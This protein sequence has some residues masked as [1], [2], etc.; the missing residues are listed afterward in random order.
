MA[1]L[2]ASMREIAEEEEAPV[3]VE[4]VE[5]QVDTVEKVHETSQPENEQDPSGNDHEMTES[6]VTEDEEA[7]E[8]GET[9]PVE[10]NADDFQH[11]HDEYDPAHASDEYDPAEHVVHAEDEYDP[12]NPSHND[13]NETQTTADTGSSTATKRPAADAASPTQSKSPKRARPERLPHALPAKA[14]DQ[15]G[16]KDAAWD[17]LMDFESSGAF[18]VSQVSRAAFSSIAAL[19]EFAQCNI[20]ARFARTPMQDIRDKNG[21]IM[22]MYHQYLDENPHIKSLQPV[23][24]FLAEAGD[25]PGLFEYGYAPPMPVTGMSSIQIPYRFGQVDK[26]RAKVSTPTV[27]STSKPQTDEFGRLIPAS[28]AP[29]RPAETSTGPTDPRRAPAASAA[30]A[31]GKPVD[32]RRRRAEQPI[33]AAPTAAPA[34]SRPADPRRRVE[35]TEVYNRLPR[36]VRSL[37]DAMIHEHRLPETINDNVLSRLNHLPEPVAMRAMEK[38]TTADLSQ[39]ENIN[40]FLVGIINRVQERT[41]TNEGTPRGA[42]GPGFQQ[43]L[44]QHHHTA[45]PAHLQG[46]PNG[47]MLPSPGMI[48]PGHVPGRFSNHPT[49]DLAIAALPV[50]VQNHLQS[51][52]GRRILASLDEF[53]EKCYEVLAQL[54]EGL[55]NEVLNRFAHANLTTVRNRSGFLIGVVKKCRQ[56]YGFNG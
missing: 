44:P 25:E 37:L 14:V 1:D 31:A 48:P 30:P 54:S 11:N 34:A 49:I 28:T 35:K 26:A 41:P 40:G 38:F 6:V 43:P 50:S 27:P 24:T 29:S 42:P 51:L 7:G 39:V 52:V 16:L 55:A 53:S 47:G 4:G 23:S 15:R 3:R 32:P 56:E 22:K 46:P 5:E 8:D 18:S 33:A 10:E 12:A 36:N 9:E 45:P 2:V 19:P 21:L 20:V 13:D 17:R